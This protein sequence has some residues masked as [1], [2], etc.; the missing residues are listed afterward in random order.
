MWVRGTLNDGACRKD[1]PSASMRVLLLL[2]YEVEGHSAYIY[3]T[4]CTHIASSWPVSSDSGEPAISVCLW[5]PPVLSQASN[6]ANALTYNSNGEALVL[7]R[8]GGSS[9]G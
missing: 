8:E 5:Q 9:A 2:I 6:W 3:G 4:I 1:V 7:G